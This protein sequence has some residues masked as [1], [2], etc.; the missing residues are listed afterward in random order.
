MPLASKYLES[1]MN[2]HFLGLLAAYLLA[3]SSPAQTI[4]IVSTTDLHGHLLPQKDQQG[5]LFGGIDLM[6]GYFNVAREDDPETLFLD[7]GDL[8]QGTIISNSH[9]GASVIKWMNYVGYTASAVGNHEFDF[10][11]GEG[12]SI[13]TDTD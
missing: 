3:V 1:S 5:H 6:A 9:D 12:H 10:G 7:S 13:V 11:P 2:I 8:F 4:H